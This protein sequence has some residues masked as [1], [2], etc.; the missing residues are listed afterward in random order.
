[1]KNKFL[2]L[3]F[4][5]LVFL[6][7]VFCRSAGFCEQ[8]SKRVVAVMPFG[9]YEEEAEQIRSKVEHWLLATGLFV[10]VERIKMQN[11]FDEM[12]LSMLGILENTKAIEIGRMLATDYLIT[13]QVNPSYKVVR[14]I[15]S[16][17]KKVEKKWQWRDVTTVEEKYEIDKLYTSVR[18]VKV[19][20]G[21]ILSTLTREGTNRDWIAKDVAYTFASLVLGRPIV[22]PFRER[23]SK[24]LWAGVGGTLF[25]VMASLPDSEIERMLTEDNEKPAQEEIDTTRA[26]FG[27]LAVGF[28]SYFMYKVFIYPDVY[29]PKG[30]LPLSEFKKRPNSRNLVKL[31]IIQLRF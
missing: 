21:E 31:N 16:E 18:L 11:L 29:R 20:T 9:G 19:D 12:K 17:R 23:L 5:V 3:F 22:L 7:S 8:M 2:R 1:M 15:V 26:F 27:L 10:A 4:V 6:G 30:H 25:L 14:E 24:Y 28:S 13:G